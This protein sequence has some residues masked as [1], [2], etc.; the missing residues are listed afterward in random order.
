MK[1]NYYFAIEYRNENRNCTTGE[2]NLRTGRMSKAI[3]IEC[4]DSM[5]SR[6][7]WIENSDS[8]RMKISIKNLREHCLGMSTEEFLS[9]IEQKKF[10]ADNC[11]N[12]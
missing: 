3:F 6:K 1:K 5:S 11:L 9:M 7:E 2:P 8:D 12:K 4:F 10:E